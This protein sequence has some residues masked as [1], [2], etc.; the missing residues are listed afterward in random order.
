MGLPCQPA[1]TARW[2]GVRQS[3]FEEGKEA[4]WTKDEV[5]LLYLSFL[6]DILCQC[7]PARPAGGATLFS[8]LPVQTA[9]GG[10]PT[11]MVPD[12]K[13]TSTV[14]SPQGLPNPELTLS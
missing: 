7:R 8:P 9:Y 1:S 11:I 5:P 13:H 4:L 14:V 10:Y 2:K 12:T 6:E 3:I